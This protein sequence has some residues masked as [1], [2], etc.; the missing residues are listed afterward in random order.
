M[1]GPS[2]LEANLDFGGP[3]RRVVLEVGLSR[4]MRVVERVF[5]PEAQAR[6]GVELV[7]H[8]GV[9]AR[10]LEHLPGDALDVRGDI[11]AQ[12]D[13]AERAAPVRVRVAVV[14][15]EGAGQLQPRDARLAR[16]GDDLAVVLVE[17][18]VV[19]LTGLASTYA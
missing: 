10:L 17:L 11:G 12:V 13:L 19:A 7:E 16:L 2:D 15:L 3:E 18:D 14:V 8:A 4:Q 5:V 1:R 6:G 9:E